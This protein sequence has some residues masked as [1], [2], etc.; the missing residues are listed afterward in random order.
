[1]SSPVFSSN[2]LVSYFR[3]ISFSSPAFSATPFS[4]ILIYYFPSSLDSSFSYPVFSYT[5]QFLF[6]S[7]TPVVQSSR[8]LPILQYSLLF[9]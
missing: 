8:L 6:L 4:F 1:L 2:P 3:Q 5:A 9:S 7:S